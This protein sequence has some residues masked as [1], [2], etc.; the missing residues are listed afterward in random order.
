MNYIQKTGYFILLFII[1]IVGIIIITLITHRIFYPFWNSQ[2]VAWTSLLKAKEGIIID[3]PLQIPCSLKVPEFMKIKKLVIPYQNKERIKFMKNHQIYWSSITKLLLTNGMDNNA[4]FTTNYI[5]WN[6][7]YPGS[8]IYCVI[9]GNKIIGVLQNIPIMVDTPYHE[10][11][12]CQWLDYLC[13]NKKYRG[14]SVVSKNIA[15]TLM[16]HAICDSSH[17][18]ENIKDKIPI[19]LFI[20]EKKL[21]FAFGA[22]FIRM[23]SIIQPSLIPDQNI[24]T[25]YKIVN[26]IKDLPLK[27]FE[28]SD[29]RIHGGA[30]LEPSSN[31][32]YKNIFWNFVINNPYHVVLSIH[33]EDWI[34]LQKMPNENGIP[35][36]SLTGFSFKN[37]SDVNL[38]LLHYLSSQKEKEIKFIVKSPIDKLFNKK[39]IWELYD[40]HYLYFY[41]YRINYKNIYIPNTWNIS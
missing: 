31:T 40:V 39:L 5:T 2:P 11:L 21:P 3:N 32:K 41:N 16:E 27:A 4:S 23:V 28:S 12:P 36:F 25:T 8:T 26:N 7:S 37:D 13:V 10:N 1:F 24:K 15:T 38:H 30:T 22:Q 19:G 34:H 17:S 14:K 6:L 35:V 9:F 20:T 33:N 29:V 18:N